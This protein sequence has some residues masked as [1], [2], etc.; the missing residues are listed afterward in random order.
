MLFSRDEPTTAASRGGVAGRAALRSLFGLALAGVLTLGLELTHGLGKARPEPVERL[1]QLQ[2]GV[3]AI[4]VALV[5][6]VFVFLRA[7]S[8]R[9]WV[10]AAGL[11][12]LLTLI[13]CGDYFKLRLRGEP[14]FVSDATYLTQTGFLVE[15][16]GAGPLLLIGAAL[17]AIPLVGW[18]FTRHAALRRGPRHPDRTQPRL[19]RHVV[20][21][22]V[23]GTMA[24]TVL[25]TAATFNV[26]GNTA[27][28]LYEAAG[29]K[30]RPWNQ[31]QNYDDNGVIAGLL[32]NLPAAPMEEPAGYS[33]GVMD[34]LAERYGEVA[35]DL[36]AD[37]EPAALADT[38]I[39]LVLSES[40]SDPLAMPD[41]TAAEDPLPFMRELMAENTSGTLLS[42]AYG[43]GTSSMEFEVLTGM[44]VANLQ[45]QVDSPFPG[46]V[47]QTESFPSH[48]RTFGDGTHS[49]YAIHPYADE[50]Y[51]RN[52]VYPALGIERA[53]FRDEL[54]GL[55]KLPGDQYISDA[56]VFE[57]VVDE[58]A[59]SQDPMVVNVVTMQNHGPQQGLANPI[60]VEGPLDDAQRETAGQYL[61]GLKASDEALEAFAADLADMDERTIVLLYGD[62]L[63]NV[64][65]EEVLD[66]SG[67]TGRYETP[68][69]VF[70]NFPTT[71]QDPGMIG[72]NQL[73]NQVL[74]SAG[75]A[76]TPWTALLHELATEI[77]AIERTG[78]LGPDGEAISE[79]DLTDRGRELLRDYRL[80]QYD[81]AAG[82][83]WATE[84][85]LAPP[86]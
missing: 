56:A 68:W 50:F 71:K 12:V 7:V 65:P 74:D 14:L 75:A 17:V 34:L 27:R 51:R 9:T 33:E 15:N 72:A 77:P 29:A 38:N 31:A 73:V 41:I 43:G 62:H 82:A 61:R 69:V 45:P 30:W 21:R 24:A 85:L 54:R 80:A 5:W 83:G 37:R 59:A 16:V 13:A 76:H 49:T 28:A 58:L 84:E 55:R 48:L 3:V 60:N 20:G 18:T 19:R 86:R 23:A 36:N 2:P 8:N 4:G 52:V 25:L 10:A 67:P 1:L 40:L 11:I 78:W 26:P 22:V 63:P 6:A 57:K 53:E 81:M 47:A 64:W 46:L 66:A 70:A 35:A 39:V 79:A 42:G 32:Y 44:A